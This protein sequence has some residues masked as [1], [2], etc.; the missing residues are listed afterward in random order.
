MYECVLPYKCWRMFVCTPLMYILREKC[1]VRVENTMWSTKWSQV[2]ATT[3]TNVI[4]RRVHVGRNWL[5]PRRS[6]AQSLSTLERGESVRGAKSAHG[7]LPSPKRVR[8]RWRCD[9]NAALKMRVDVVL[10]PVVVVFAIAI[11][12]AHGQK[13]NYSNQ[14]CPANCVCYQRTVRCM[15]LKLVEVPEIPSS[16]HTAW[17]FHGFCNE[18]SVTCTV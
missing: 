13:R 3:P 9:I 11:A 16:T 8:F 10:P 17:V 18:T 7:P 1:R 15:Q 5:A 2:P 14:P 4:G 6:A 12:I